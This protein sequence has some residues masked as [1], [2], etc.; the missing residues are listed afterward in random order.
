MMQIYQT[1]WFAQ[2]AD[3]QGV[4][5]LALQEAIA[6]IAQGLVDANLGGHLFKKRIGLQGRGKSTGVRTIVALKRQ[7]KA[8]YL[9]G[10]AKNALDNIDAKEL[11]ALKKLATIYFNFS[12][13]QLQSALNNGNLIEVKHND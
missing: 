6:E 7:N 9:Y 10:F 11:Q 13:E 12:D 4:S 5:A 8:F 2:W 1:K 3:K